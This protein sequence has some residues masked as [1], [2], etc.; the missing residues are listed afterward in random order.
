MI[1]AKVVE[2]MREAFHPDPDDAVGEGFGRGSRHSF[3]ASSIMR[4]AWVAILS[5][6]FTNKQMPSAPRFLYFKKTV[7]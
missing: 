4:I 1:E 5:E 6:N 2:R 3:P 7:T